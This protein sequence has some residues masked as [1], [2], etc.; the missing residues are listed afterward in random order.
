MKGGGRGS[1]SFSDPLV[2]TC[3]LAMVTVATSYLTKV[4]SD[5]PCNSNNCLLSALSRMPDE[6]RNKG[7][8]S[9]S[10]NI[11]PL[12]GLFSCFFNYNTLLSQWWIQVLSNV[13]SPLNYVARP[14]AKLLVMVGLRFHRVWHMSSVLGKS[15]FWLEQ[16][17]RVPSSENIQMGKNIDKYCTYK[18]KMILPTFIRPNFLLSSS[19]FPITGL[20]NK[21]WLQVRW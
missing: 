8:I 9:Y 15:K 12:S 2:V 4:S 14:Y 10:L 19:I 21:S 6:L 11:Y 17:L 18:I 3:Y 7:L 16:Q 13:S 5:L 20:R 1:A